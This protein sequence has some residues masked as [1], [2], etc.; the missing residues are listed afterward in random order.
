MASI[1]K[2]DN[3]KWWQASVKGIRNQIG[4]QGLGSAA[5]ICVDPSPRGECGDLLDR[6]G[7]E[8]SIGKRGHRIE[9][10]R[11]EHLRQD[12]IARKRPGD[13]VTL[14]F[15]QWRDRRLREVKSNTV[16]RELEQMSAVLSKAK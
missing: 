15:A 12:E 5:G 14:D 16:R 6:Y 13:L 3:G 4:D 1:T 10:V 8:V 7:R 2:Q 11:I 9:A